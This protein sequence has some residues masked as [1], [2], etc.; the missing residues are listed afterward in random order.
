MLAALFVTSLVIGSE[1]WAN[2]V[3]DL[4]ISTSGTNGPVVFYLETGPTYPPT[5]SITIFFS[6]PGGSGLSIPVIPNLSLGTCPSTLSSGSTCT[7]TVDY[8]VPRSVE[9]DMQDFS[10]TDPTGD[11]ITD[12]V[13]IEFEP[14]LAP[15]PLPT[16]LLAFA[17]GLGL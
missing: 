9:T 8:S 2:T 17:T 10:F 15:T 12:D 13:Q 4:D 1:A 3:F 5:A 11:Q 14:E 7:E 6:N 16:S